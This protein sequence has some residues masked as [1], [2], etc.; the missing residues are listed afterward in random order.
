M[1][2]GGGRVGGIDQTQD[3]FGWMKAATILGLD[4]EKMV[5]VFHLQQLFWLP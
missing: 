2:G 5:N 3:V 4:Y 1:L